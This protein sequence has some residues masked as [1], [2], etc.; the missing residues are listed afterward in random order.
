MP[1]DTAT[2]N[3]VPER[4]YDT[5]RWSHVFS[6]NRTVADRPFLETYRETGNIQGLVVAFLQQSSSSVPSLE[7][8]RCK[9]FFSSSQSKPEVSPLQARAWVHRCRES[10]EILGCRPSRMTSF[11]VNEILLQQVYTGLRSQ[12][13]QT[14]S[15]QGRTVNQQFDIDRLLM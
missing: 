14:K 11:Q 5:K 6:Q 13:P 12:L 9:A 1:E 15:L 4:V 7:V 2:T 10:S 8:E 3:A